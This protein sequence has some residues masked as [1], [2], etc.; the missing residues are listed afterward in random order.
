MTLPTKASSFL[1]RDDI[2][3]T[4]VASNEKITIMNE[5]KKYGLTMIALLSLSIGMKAQD[6]TNEK[7]RKE[8]TKDKFSY[9]LL[10]AIAFDAD[11]GV[12]YGGLVSVYDYRKPVTYPDYRQMWKMEISRFTKG[13]GIN[14][15]YYD[16]K[17]MLP[18]RLRLVANLAYMT[19]QKLDFFGF[20]G[21]ESGYN[22]N[23]VDDASPD[24]LTRVFYGHGREQFRFNSELIGHLPW[25]NFYWL[26]GIG[27]FHTKVS[28]VDIDHLNKGKDD[29]K[30]LPNTP[31]LYDKY[32]EWG[33]IPENEKDG[34]FSNYFK[35]GFLYDTR[36]IEANPSRGIWT[37]A[38]IVYAPGF[39]FNDDV[40]FCK[41]SAT[42]RQYFTLA[43]AKLI[44]AYRLMYQGTIGGYMPFYMQPFMIN[45]YSPIT[46]LDGLGGA[47]TMR[48]VMRNRVVGDGFIM[49][50]AELRWKVFNTVIAKQNF[51]VGLNA[52]MDAGMV[53]QQIKFDESRIP[54]ADKSLYFDTGYIN[55][56]DG[57]HSGAG[58]GLRAVLNENFI[59]A[60]DYGLPLKKQDGDKGGL[61]ISIGNLF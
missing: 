40:N 39:F 53:V 8:Q 25:E 24:Y 43:P 9:G 60:I 29:D 41:L 48:G 46:K 37:E 30:K 38:L 12:Q 28:A 59:L 5:L 34:G 44:F 21:Y 23:F 47:K 31:T 32:V 7:T 4:F 57:L 42:H 6:A 49:G 2:L 18:H 10:P 3:V 58:L 52:F 54:A 61:Y 45:A 1:A 55:K 56:N 22:P 33:I 14:Q 51:Y 35:A 50:N 15:L 17:N 26:G 36:D 11:L 16:A 19:E 13:S 27:V 20:N